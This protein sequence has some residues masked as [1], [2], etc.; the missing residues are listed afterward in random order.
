MSFKPARLD[1]PALMLTGAYFC[2]LAIAALMAISGFAPLLGLAAAM[3]GIALA[4][5][6]VAPREY[7]L[8]DD[9]ITVNRTLGSLRVEGPLEVE[10]VSAR[11]LVGI[12]M[13]L[14]SGGLFGY[15]GSYRPA[16]VRYASALTRRDG[17]LLVRGEGGGVLISPE[18][19]DALMGQVSSR[20]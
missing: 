2:A 14:G 8:E 11:E 3:G 18:D 9:G 15:L 17:A 6:L 1:P 16:G 5:A 20:D 12:K 19:A 13:L 10:T 4:C 7:V